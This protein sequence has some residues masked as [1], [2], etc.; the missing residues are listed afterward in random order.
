M[1]SLNPI[2]SSLGEGET[3]PF[4]MFTLGIVRQ[5]GWPVGYWADATYQVLVVDE[6]LASLSRHCLSTNRY[7]HPDPVAVADVP[8]VASSSYN[9]GE[10]LQTGM[11]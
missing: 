2:R 6:F 7:Y 4:G 1:N 5:A 9:S 11:P 10:L 3:D 8:C